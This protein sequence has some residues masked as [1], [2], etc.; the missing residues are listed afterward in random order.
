[1]FGN[2]RAGPNG[3]SYYIT[4]CLLLEDGQRRRMSLDPAYP[5]LLSGTTPE[6]GEEMEHFTLTTSIYLESRRN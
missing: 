3:T 5:W 4:V 6:Y 1:M 2:K